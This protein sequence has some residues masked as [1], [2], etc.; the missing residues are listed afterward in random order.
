MM[1][2][3]FG[4][5]RKTYCLEVEIGNNLLSAIVSTAINENHC[6]LKLSADEKKNGIA[7]KKAQRS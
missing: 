4:L 6:Y 3:G 2:D 7:A 1:A 5:W